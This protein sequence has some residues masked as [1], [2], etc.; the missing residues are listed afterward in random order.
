MMIKPL[1][2][3]V[4]KE[5]RIGSPGLIIKASHCPLS[6]STFSVAIGLPLPLDESWGS[7]PTT[8]FRYSGGIP[9]LW[10]L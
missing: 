10:S 2:I 5:D 6:L 4:G 3:E 1:P 7:Y 8:S 9:S